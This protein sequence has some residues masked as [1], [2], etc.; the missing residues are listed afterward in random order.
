MTLLQRIKSIII[1]AIMIATAIMI[2]VNLEQGYIIL[3]F[4]LAAGLIVAGIGSLYYYLSMGRFIVGGRMFLYR[5]LILIDIGSFALTLSDVP[6]IYVLLYLMFIHTFSGIVEILRALESRQYGARS[7]KLKMSHGIV[8]LLVVV[9]CFIFRKYPE[10]LV[11]VYSLG[12]AYSG[13]MNIISA[14]RKRSFIY[15]Q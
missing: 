15:I 1:G 7:W 10:T 2:N 8:N 14:L 4:I 12:I 9:A 11:I 3:L 13:V 5:G 6:R